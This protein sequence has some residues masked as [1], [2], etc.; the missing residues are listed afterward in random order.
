MA[1]AWALTEESKAFALANPWIRS[2]L[3]N[4][5]PHSD[6]ALP[7]PGGRLVQRT[8]EWPL[9]GRR[10]DVIDRAL[11]RLARARLSAHYAHCGLDVP[12]SI[13]ERL[14]AGTELR[15]HG[16]N[17][18]QAILSLYEARRSAIER[19]LAG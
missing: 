13:A 12:D 7:L 15:F 2:E 4:A 19:L 11:G 14:Q 1:Q 10:G 17:S 9:R 8:L 3:P 16:V 5:A 6:P 18:E